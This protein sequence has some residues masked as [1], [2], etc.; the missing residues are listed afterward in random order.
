MVKT[1]E[2]CRPTGGKSLFYHHF[3]EK[4]NSQNMPKQ[5]SNKW[6]Q[7]IKSVLTPQN[8]DNCMVVQNDICA[9]IHTCTQTEYMN[10]CIIH[11]H[12]HALH[13]LVDVVTQQLQSKAQLSQ[14]SPSQILQRQQSRESLASDERPDRQTS[15]VPGSKRFLTHAQAR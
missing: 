15:K 4:R 6:F 14:G 9:Y 12:T 7:I 1:K 5:L 13:L 2:H 11:T 8:W 10:I 3:V